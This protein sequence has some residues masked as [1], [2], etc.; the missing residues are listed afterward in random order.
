MHILTWAE[1]GSNWF[2]IYPGIL[3]L[4]VAVAFGLG[5]LFGR[6]SRRKPLARKH[7]RYQPTSDSRARRL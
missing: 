7:Y 4:F 5:F 3:L 2:L 6:S 1:S